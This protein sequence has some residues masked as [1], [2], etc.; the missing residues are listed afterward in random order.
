MEEHSITDEADFIRI[1]VQLQRV[2]SPSTPIRKRE[3]FAG[4][5][6][7]V[8]RLLGAVA[9][10]GQHALLYG[11][12]GVGKT[13]L[14]STIRDFWTDGT[15]DVDTV[16]VPRVNCDAE[17]TFGSIWMKVADEIQIIAE[18][19]WLQFPEG[20]PA[21]ELAAEELRNGKA[22][23]TTV[24]HYFELSQKLFIV[25]IDEFDRVEDAVTRRLIADTIKSLSDHSTDATIIV[26][27]VADT[28][29]QLLQEHASIDRALIQVLTPRMSVQ[30]L[31][32]IIHKGITKVGMEVETEVLEFFS[33]LAQGL[34][35]YAHLLGLLAATHAVG[36]RR[37]HVT[38]HDA[39]CAVQLG[40]DQ[41]QASVTNAYH[42]ATTSPRH[43]LW[44]EVLLACAL[45]EVDDLGYFAP[46]DV[47]EPMS[48]IMGE[49]CEISR[50]V[51]HLGELCTEA[52]GPILQ[53]TGPKGR[54]RFRFANPLMK[55]FIVMRGLA[56]GRI[57]A[58]AAKFRVRH[59]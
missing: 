46:V 9:Q 30:E 51:R 53:K 26:V 38:M 5:F 19:R 22:T 41:A 44:R 4:R 23:P 37:K 25:V 21:F 56:D 18:K 29:D 14:A 8:S 32:E 11:E 48:E 28:V 57:E 43:N 58:E 45:A 39:R 40:L 50:F 24:R 13:S 31:Q 2:F 55:P 20:S 59:V 10:V 49:R 36:C 52:R 42:R 6:N 27:G 54:Q 7:E 34:P 1:Q 16:L 35:H 15:A 47:R 17:D 12:R 3:L 33:S